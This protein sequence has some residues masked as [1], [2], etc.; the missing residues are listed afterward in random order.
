MGVGVGA[1]RLADLFDPRGS[2]FLG[3][4]LHAVV[5]CAG[6][7]QSGHEYGMAHCS[8]D[9]VSYVVWLCALAPDQHAAQNPPRAT[10]YGLRADGIHRGFASA[11]GI[12]L[13]ST[14]LERRLAAHQVGLAEQPA[15]SQ[16]V[17][18][19]TST[20]ADTLRRHGVP[21]GEAEGQG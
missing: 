6:F 1:G 2:I 10:E 4:L 13:G 19:I 9:R 17:Q 11:F 20:V 7:H 18:D 14:M 3:L 15:L 12:A 21:G 16:Q 8:G 5:V